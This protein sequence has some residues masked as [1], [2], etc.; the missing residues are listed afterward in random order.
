M[1]IGRTSPRLK[2]GGTYRY[3]DLSDVPDEVETAGFITFEA[4]VSGN[5]LSC[6]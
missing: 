5:D 6:L 2:N 1:V 3:F 4:E